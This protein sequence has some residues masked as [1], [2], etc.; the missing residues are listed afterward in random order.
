[1]IID[2]LDRADA[3]AALHPRFTAAFAFLRRADLALL[4]D[5]RHAIE[6]DQV[7]AMVSHYTTRAVPDTLRWETHREYIDVQYLAAGR[8]AIG[9]TPVTAV[10][11]IEPYDAAKDVAFHAGAGELVIMAEGQFAVF[12]PDD[13]HAPGLA[14]G[15]AQEVLKVV[16]KVRCQQEPAGPRDNAGKLTEPAIRKKA[17]RA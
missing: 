14:A 2:A 7:Y 8:E 5:G 16:V 4:P 12:F 13:A 15:G 3:Y 1:M 9:W 11:N 10:Q 6:G 17:R